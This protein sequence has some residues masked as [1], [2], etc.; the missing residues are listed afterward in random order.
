[1]KP[2]RRIELTKKWYG[3]Y[4]YLNAAMYAVVV[5]QFI[6]FAVDRD[7]IANQVVPDLLMKT[8]QFETSEGLNQALPPEKV[9]VV[10]LLCALLFGTF[11]A[12]AAWLP[13]AP[14]TK[15]Y[16][17]VHFVNIVLGAGSCIFTPVC[18]WLLFQ[19]LNKDISAHYQSQE[20]AT[21]QT[22]E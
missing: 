16:Y 22:G 4:C 10:C 21:S 6:R 20:P 1:M 11:A 15:N 7:R 5:A 8:G 17:V 2:D 9:L 12:V 14:R 18:I 19:F 13:T 3:A